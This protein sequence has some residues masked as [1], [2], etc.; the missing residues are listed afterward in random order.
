MANRE[1]EEVAFQGDNQG[2]EPQKKSKSRRNDKSQGRDP[3]V[4]PVK[5]VDEDIVA[6]EYLTDFLSEST[7]AKEV[8]RQQVAAKV[9]R[10][11]GTEASL[12]PIGVVMAKATATDHRNSAR[13]MRSGI[14]E[15]TTEMDVICAV[16]PL[17]CTETTQS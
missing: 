9:N 15:S 17:I 14:R 2:N 5:D 11:K 1:E 8:T 13:T 10:E 16:T 6:A 4:A 7:K 3:S 12:L